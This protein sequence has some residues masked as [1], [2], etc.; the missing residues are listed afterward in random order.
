MDRLRAIRDILSG[1]VISNQEALLGLLR[2]QGF[3]CTQSSVSRDLA[4]LG[5]QKIQGRYS[6]APEVKIPGLISGRAAG[7][8]L[9]V[10]RTEIGAASL[11]AL[12]ID[13]LGLPEVIGTLA[14]DDT[15]FLA[16][17]DAQSQ[18]ALLGHLGVVA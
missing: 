3:A 10:L 9:L 6:L 8:N 7:P 18:S 13:N 1:E 4:D 15:I 14:G 12:K 11:I 16:T 2:Q 5:V 17:S